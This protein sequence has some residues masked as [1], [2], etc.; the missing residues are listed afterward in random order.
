[1]IPEVVQDSVVSRALLRSF[2]FLDELAL[3]EASE[4][5][6]QSQRQ[7]LIHHGSSSSPDK[8][9]TSVSLLSTYGA[10][11]PPQ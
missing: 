7:Q 2:G 5:N 11:A 4:S 6:Q 9:S 10:T 8:S 3:T 1:M